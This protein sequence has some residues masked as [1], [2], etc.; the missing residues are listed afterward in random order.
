MK[1]TKLLKHVSLF[2]VLRRF[3]CK[4]DIN[5]PGKPILADFGLWGCW[6]VVQGFGG[7]VCVD[8]REMPFHETHLN[9]F[10]RTIG[11]CDLTAADGTPLQEAWRASYGDRIK[12]RL[13][14][15]L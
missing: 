4:K 8:G 9:D 13:E 3:R 6:Y 1:A 11:P 7:L 14:A 2:P 5:V 15:A 10:G 12:E